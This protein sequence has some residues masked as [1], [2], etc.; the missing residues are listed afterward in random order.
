V[1][2][3]VHI[4]DR[5]PGGLVAGTRRAEELGVAAVWTTQGGVTPDSMVLLGAAGAATQR[6][7]LG[8][9]VIPT[10]PRAAILIAQQVMAI[11]SLAP[12]RFRLGIGPSTPAAMTPLYDADYRKPLSQLR[13]YLTVIRAFLHEGEV[14]FHGEFVG[15]KVRL[16]QPI[17]APVMASALSP[18]AFRLCGEAADGA[19]SWMAPWTYLRDVALPAMREGAAAANRETPA[20][21]AHVPVCLTT[22]PDEARRVT[23]DHVGPYGTFPVY[24]A[25]F[26][27]AGFDDTA[28]GFSQP[29]IDDLVAYGSEDQIVERL[30][31]IRSEGAA[32]IVTQV[33]TIGDDHAAYRDRA[34]NL[35]ARAQSEIG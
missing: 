35:L 22:D 20:L 29:L 19:I 9:S 26:R 25:M 28:E 4:Q 8:T 10:W 34:F 21:V 17:D 7:K 24:Q 13:E 27:A 1:T 2:I 15:A 30:A 23:Q 33:L 14:D 12:G 11:D 16:R 5:E 3:G 6:I 31:Q 18:R 32:E